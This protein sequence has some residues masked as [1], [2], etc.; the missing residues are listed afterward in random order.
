MKEKQSLAMGGQA[1]LE[2]VMFRGGDRISL[3]VRKPNGG[4]HIETRDSKPLNKGHNFFKLP[5]VRGTMNLVDSMKLGV[6][7]LTHSANIS[8][9]EEGEKL[10]KRDI[11][12][13]VFF[14]LAAT[15]GLFFV[16][17]TMLVEL[18]EWIFGK[19]L[20]FKNIMEGIIRL[21]IFLSYILIIS[22]LK[23]IYRVFQY[24]GAEHMVVHCYEQQEELTVENVSK[25]SPL[26][27][28]CGTSFLLL[29]MVIS[30]AIFS[31]LPWM[32]LIPRIL[33]RIL[34]VPL[35]AGVAYEITKLAGKSKSPVINAIMLPGLYLQKLTTR[36]PDVKQIE[37]AIAAMNAA[38]EPDLTEIDIESQEIYNENDIACKVE[39]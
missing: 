22:K 10:S 3:A 2:G 18:L 23:E 21:S 1:V 6:E 4:I 25:Y 33:L 35:I 30:V 11:F 29:V 17:P 27:K 32:G 28:R 38:V 31:M 7:M 5:F 15:I 12:F 34:V 14:A 9:G 37:V 20:A 16:A 19:D 8:E 39:V 24:H 36:I 26:H 13:A